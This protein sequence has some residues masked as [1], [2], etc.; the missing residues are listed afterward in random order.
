MYLPLMAWFTIRR[1]MCSP[2]QIRCSN[3]GCKRPFRMLLELCGKTT[4]L[5]N[6]YPQDVVLIQ[7]LVPI[8]FDAINIG[9]SKIELFAIKICAVINE[10]GNTKPVTQ[11]AAPV[12]V[13]E[14][15]T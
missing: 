14:A 6:Q 3:R 5:L 2:K 1:E 7:Y 4:L 13:V 12:V 9:V 15:P 8:G 10:N 11:V